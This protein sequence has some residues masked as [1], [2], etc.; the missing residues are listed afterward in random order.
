MK[1]VAGS[2]RFQDV[3]GNIFLMATPISPP[4]EVS[5]G[6]LRFYSDALG[7]RARFAP[8]GWGTVAGR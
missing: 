3:N 8:G 4:E 7:L 6:H 2:D 5:H 1:F